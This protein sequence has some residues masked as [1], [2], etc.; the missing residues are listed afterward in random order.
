MSGEKFT[1]A[2]CL[3]PGPDPGIDAGNVPIC[4]ECWEQI[5]V[6]QRAVIIA[7][8]RQASA[9]EQQA[10][11]IAEAIQASRNGFIDRRNQFGSN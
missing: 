5:P 8:F 6:G 3:R 9:A 1:C 7:R 2:V 10:A 11:W 4:Q